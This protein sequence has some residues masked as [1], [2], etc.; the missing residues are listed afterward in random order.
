MEQQQ[1]SESTIKDTDSDESLFIDAL[2]SFDSNLI[3]NSSSIS[4][5]DK[6]ETFVGFDIHDSTTSSTDDNNSTVSS[7]LK[8]PEKSKSK[9]QSSRVRSS[10]NSLL[11]KRLIEKTADDSSVITSVNNDRNIDN[12]SIAVDSAVSGSSPFVA[13]AGLVT[14]LIGIQLSM[15]V[16]SVTFPIWLAYYSYVFMI[17]PFRS[18]TLAKQYIFRKIWR[19]FRRCKGCVKW[20]LYTFIRKNEPTWKFCLQIC[21]GLLWSIYVGFIL[22]SLLVF[23]FVIS[24]I[25]LKYVIEEPIRMTQDLSFDYTKDSP[26]AFVPLMSCPEPSFLECSELIKPAVSGESRIIPLDH[27]VLAT[28]SLT[29]PES[30]YNRNL[31]IFQVRVDFLSGNGQRLASSRQPCMLHFR[32][33]PIRLM[34]TLLKLAPLITGYSSETQTLKI[35]FKGYTERNVP[36]SCLRVILEQRAEFTKGAGVPEIYEA[37]M[38][39][40]SQ[41]PFLKRILWSWKGTLYIWTTIMIFMVELLFTLVCCTPVIVPWLQPTRVPSNRIVS[42]NPRP[43]P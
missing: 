19:I 8:S 9:F 18:V 14:K 27:K 23:A 3:P 15:L 39:L 20:I 2:E 11:R 21:W 28:V 17:D 6:S 5:I 16:R 35:K 30:Y 24:G 36:T 10:S 13:L 41:Q 12:E 25:L 32:S 37:Y 43:V 22:I 40:E 26:T 31:G 42:P 34:L 7:K 1:H 4:E 33:Q 38:K 29:L